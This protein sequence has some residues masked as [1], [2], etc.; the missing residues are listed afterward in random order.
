MA[1][2]LESRILWGSLLVLAGILFLLQNIFAFEFGDLFWTILL[3]LGGLFFI[4]VYISNRQ[5]WW[6]LIPGVV[7]LAVATLILVDTFFPAVGNLIGASIVLGGIGLS[8]TL[9]YLTNRDNWWAVIPA[10]VMW[11]LAIVVGLENMLSD[12]GF[13]SLFFLGLGITFAI[14]TILPVSGGKMKWAWIPAGILALMG[15]LFGAFS[16]DLAVYIWPAALIIAGLFMII[17]T[18]TSRS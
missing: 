15:L 13:V 3:V 14:L 2:L 5:H 4:S 11:T 12:T 17:R 9:V 8:F 16:G 18:F 1:K 7:L 10:G 6:A